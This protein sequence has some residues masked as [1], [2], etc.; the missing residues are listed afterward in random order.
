VVLAADD[1]RHADGKA[2]W[3]LIGAV[4]LVFVALALWI[5]F[6]GT[7]PGPLPPIPENPSAV[8]GA[9]QKIAFAAGDLAVGDSLLCENQGV[10]VGAWV[11]KPGHTAHAQLV[12]SEA[13]ATIAIHTRRDGVVIA[14]C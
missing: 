11:P 4:A 9:G 2:V 10:L 3:L 12:A 6:G 13:T 8:L 5:R 7:A 14:R 1:V